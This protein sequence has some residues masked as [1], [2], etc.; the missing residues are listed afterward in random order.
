MVARHAHARRKGLSRTPSPMDDLV[1]EPWGAGAQPRWLNK[2]RTGGIAQHERRNGG[3]D[4]EAERER[5]SL[6]GISTTKP[7]ALLR[8]SIKIRKAGDEMETEP[9]FFE[10]EPVAHCGPI[11]KGEFLRTLTMTD[12]IMG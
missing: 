6:K 11:L 9:G 3:P 8:H 1:R 4:L 12:G 7:G 2:E 5:L 10:M